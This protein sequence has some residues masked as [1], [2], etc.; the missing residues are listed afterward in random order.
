[1]MKIRQ[2]IRKIKKGIKDAPLSAY[3]VFS[4]AMII[5]FTIVMIVI[6][7]V[8]DSIPDTLVTCYYSCFA[9]EVLCVSLIKIFKL[10]G[11]DD[12]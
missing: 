2:K 11:N 4:L 3:V 7:C 9:G 12:E 5:I 10:R 8:K 1:M 6:F